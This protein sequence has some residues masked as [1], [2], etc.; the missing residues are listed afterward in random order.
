MVNSRVFVVK[1][2]STQ[3]EHIVS[4]SSCSSAVRHSKRFR[5]LL[6]GCV[7]D[8]VHADSDLFV[9]V[10]HLKLH[11]DLWTWVTGPLPRTITRREG[12]VYIRKL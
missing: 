4:I 9:G 11:T 7:V 2:T 10:V 3:E 12:G 5:A 8:T 6:E 1:Q